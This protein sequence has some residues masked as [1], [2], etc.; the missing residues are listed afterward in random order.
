M[1]RKLQ[2]NSVRF[3]LPLLFGRKCLFSTINQYRFYSVDENGENKLNK[4]I[5]MIA[6]TEK[7]LGRPQPIQDVQ[8][9]EECND[10]EAHDHVFPN[11]YF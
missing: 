8:P 9:E 11:Q 6:E 5:S 2:F 3:T 10:T 4:L 1:L 7:K